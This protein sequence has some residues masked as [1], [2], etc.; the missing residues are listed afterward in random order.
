MNSSIICIS[1]PVLY[2]IKIEVSNN[3]AYIIVC[4]I[5]K[6]SKSVTSKIF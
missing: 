5:F 4:E 3:Q 2:F 1:T 6:K